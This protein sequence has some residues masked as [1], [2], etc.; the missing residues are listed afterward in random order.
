MKNVIKYY[1]NFDVD[2][3]TTKDDY[4]EFFYLN[5]LYHFK[6]LEDD[7]M[8]E[9]KIKML[10]EYSKNNY[11]IHEIIPNK[12]N[13]LISVYNN[14]PFVLYEVNINRSLDVTLRE[15]QYLS[16]T[17]INNEKN[18]IPDWG[19]LWS[20]KVDY[21]EL[22][23]NENG[24]KMP[25]LVD[26]FN[27]FV[28]LTENAIAYYNN[29][30]KNNIELEKSSVLSHRKIKKDDTIYSIYNPLNIIIDHKSRDIAEYIKLSFFRKNKTIFSELQEYFKYNYYSHTD[31]R[32]LFA[33]ILYPSFYFDLYD[34][35]IMGIKEEKEII[36]ITNNI[37]QYIVYLNTIFNLLS[38]YYKLE[39]I[40]WLKKRIVNLH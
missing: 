33:R 34:E 18:D 1:Y 6:I 40:T 12:F 9:K 35:I 25:L 24:K 36:N 14:I 3:I 29:T 2:E 22:Q 7:S 27:F 38:R 13:N 23:I 8:N 4:Y 32:I 39:E 15:I 19:E 30:T 5:D 31:I 21:L 20:K 26:S 37:N 17:H 11:L 28:G 16:K 10:Y